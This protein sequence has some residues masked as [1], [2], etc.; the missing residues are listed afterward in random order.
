MVHVHEQVSFPFPFFGQPGA[1]KGSDGQIKGTDKGPEPAGAGIIRV[2]QGF[3]LEIDIVMDDLTGLMVDG[4][5][6]CSEALVPLN[7]L[8]KCG[9]EFFRIQCSFEDKKPGQVVPGAGVV[10]LVKY[11]KSAL[12]G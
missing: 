1:D 11:K 12:G 2:R 4:E 3:D 7:Q 9:L 5:K 10:E 8:K 6:R